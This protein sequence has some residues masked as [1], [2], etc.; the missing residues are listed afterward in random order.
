MTTKRE[1]ITGAHWGLFYAQIEN[2]RV[3][4]VRPFEQDPH[5][6]SM[7]EATPDL[8]HSETRITGPMVR[9]GYLQ[10]GHRSDTRCRGADPFVEVTWDQALDLIHAELQRVFNEHGN[11]SLFA[12]SYGWASAGKF[13]AAPKQ[14]QRFLNQVGGFTFHKGNYS[15]GAVTF[16][17]PY[18]L[19]DPW[20]LFAP[21]SWA[22]IA[23]H[24]QLFVTFGGV[25]AKNMQADQG[26]IGTHDAPDWLARTRAGG[27]EFVNISPLASDIDDY[28]DA[29]WLP[30]RPNTDTAIML[31]LC[32]TLYTENLWDQ[33]FGED[34]CV[35]IEK[36]I[37]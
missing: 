1:V 2:E 31:A 9:K 18:L 13:H 17:A 6:S 29:Q 22:S 28:L 10:K 12:G 33:R 8:V 32:H 5:P 11:Q 27:T 4:G 7:I 37:P 21:T 35:G 19:G 36:I 30:C 15:A 14:L 25:P 26:G 20:F 23:Q 34:Y 3:T 24:T 16:L